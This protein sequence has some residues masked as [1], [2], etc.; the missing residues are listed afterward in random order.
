MTTVDD[1]N[2]LLK[3]PEK[4]NLEF[5]TAK[6]SFSRDKDLPDYCAALANEGGGKLILGVNN[7]RE[8]VGSKAFEGTHNTLSNDLLSKINIRV[9]IEEL[10][11]PQGRILIFHVPSRPIG[12]AIRSTG[13]YHYPMRAGESLVEM[14]QIT[15]KRIL[16]E[17]D[18]DFSAQIVEGLRLEDLDEK[19]VVNF[20]R[21]WAEKSKRQD[22]LAFTSEKA[23]QSIGLLTDKGLNYASLILFGKKE[24]LAELLPGCELIFEWR[25]DAKKTA[26]D[27]RKVWREPFFNICDEIWETINARNIRIP[28]QEALFQREIFAFSEKPV[29]EAILNA[30]AHRDY[31]IRNQSIFINASPESFVIESPGSLPPGITI[32]NICHKRYWRNRCIAETFE[33]AALV[34]RSGQGMDDIFEFTI[35]EGKGLPDLSKSDAF[36]V[37]LKIPAQVK[38][39]NFI[40]FLEKIINEKQFALS[41]DEI[42]ELEKIR[43]N[44]P[45]ANVE[46]RDKFLAGGIIEQVGKTK[47]AKYI[48]LHKYYA[49]EGKVGLHTKLTGISREKYKELIIKHLGKNKGYRHDLQD[50]FPELNP[51]DISN[52]LQ[53]LKRGKKIVFSGTRRD[54]YWALVN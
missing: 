34:E 25:Q 46:S 21:R 32:E 22:Y 30:V 19:A 3:Q 4:E 31:T 6:N 11:L 37:C 45:V 29:R 51:Q 9:D 13:N 41:F 33:K 20:K 49:H 2:R 23:L 1:L 12:Q 52:I 15:L 42:Y 38:D 47:G 26:H 50:A 35:K 16:N 40:L 28:F 14:D 39:K 48:L 8:I 10:I 18:T 7:N 5:K 44:Q 27:F 54:G 17:A 24:K 43:E 53:E 36:S